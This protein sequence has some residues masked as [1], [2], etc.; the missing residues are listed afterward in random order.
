MQ[1]LI[2]LVVV[3]VTSFREDHIPEIDHL[4]GLRLI[5]EI[6]DDF[7]DKWAHIP[8][9]FPC[10]RIT[11]KEFII[12][13]HN[14]LVGKLYDSRGQLV[15]SSIEIDRFHIESSLMARLNGI[16]TPSTAA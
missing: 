12:N 9:W 11:R 14:V 3:H 4:F 15:C 8:H 5:V 13:F 6:L 7:R 1:Q 10:G 16:L 2:F